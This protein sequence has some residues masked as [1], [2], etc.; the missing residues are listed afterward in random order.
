MKRCTLLPTLCVCVF[1]S[2][3]AA[4]GDGNKDEGVAA[5]P[6]TQLAATLTSNGCEPAA[7]T[8][9]TGNVTFAVTNKGSKTLE[10]YVLSGTKVVAEAENIAPNF[11]KSVTAK[12]LK[13][14]DYVLGCGSKDGPNGTLKVTG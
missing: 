2:L 10:L 1:L 8:A 11:V 4:C 12:D 6:G 13:A 9:P 3:L 14:G 7:L 5:N